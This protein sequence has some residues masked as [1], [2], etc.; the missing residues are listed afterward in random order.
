MAADL[1]FF[2]GALVPT[3]LISR[4]FLWLSKRW[5][6]SGRLALVH[7]ASALVSCTL[8]AFGHADNDTLNWSH[9]ATYI[10]AQMVLF[11]ID[12]NRKERQVATKEQSPE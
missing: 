4:L 7:A 3:F 11:F 12:M 8:S 2:I 9:S 5:S 10:I 6:G 1:V